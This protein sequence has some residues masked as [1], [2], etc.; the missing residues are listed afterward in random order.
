MTG[1]LVMINADDF[2]IDYCAE[3]GG[4]GDHREIDS[5]GSI[6]YSCKSCPFHTCDDDT[7]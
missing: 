7:E 5:D 4:Y 6:I 1:D 3:C 2:E